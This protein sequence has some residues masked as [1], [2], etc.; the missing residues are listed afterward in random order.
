MKMILLKTEQC[1]LWSVLVKTA[2]HSHLVNNTWIKIH[3]QFI[4]FSLKADKNLRYKRE[5]IETKLD[6]LSLITDFKGRL[7][8]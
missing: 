8:L 3:L 1:F 5:K 7:K 4:L 6:R 2:L